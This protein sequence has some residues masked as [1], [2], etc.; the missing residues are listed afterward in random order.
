MITPSVFFKINFF[1]HGLECWHHLV[2]HNVQQLSKASS[3]IIQRY[4]RVY[5]SRLGINVYVSC[6]AN[7]TT[8]NYCS[9]SP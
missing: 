3:L 8:L 7:G 5:T 9:L 6:V 1:F 4:F 2:H